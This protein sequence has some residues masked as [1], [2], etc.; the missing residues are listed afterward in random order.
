V[1]ELIIIAVYF[2]AM[3]AIGIWNRRKSREA[4]DFFVAGRK[5]STLFIT[6][7]LIATII[8]GSAIMVTGRLGFTRGISGIWWLL[9]GTAG[10]LILGIFLAGKV[11]KY[12]VYTL[13]EILDKQYGKSVSIV[14]S[15]IIVIAWTGVIGTQIMAAGSIMSTLGIGTPLLWMVVFSAVF[16]IYTLIGGQ[17]AIIKTDTI[18]SVI[19]FAGIFI[20]L[21]M[22]ISGLGG[23]GGLVE[24]LPAERFSFPFGTGFDGYD[25]VNL[26]LLVGLTYVVG[27]DIYSRLFCARDSRIAGKSAIGAALLIIPAALAITIIGMGASILY[28]DILPDSAF[29]AI[30]SGVLPP[31]LGGIVL[32]ALLCAFMSSADTTLMT[33]GTILSMDIIGRLNPSLEG[34]K[35]LA[36]SRFGIV[37]IGTASLLLSL[38]MGDLVNTILFA[39]TVYT[40]GLIIPILAGFYKD[41]LKVTPG[42]ALAAIIGG[43]GTALTARLFSISISI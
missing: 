30:I 17:H 2:L 42:G 39:Y 38:F 33:A 34:K 6:G 18:Q 27:P 23:I 37:I 31:F 12:G 26:L 7:S 20:A 36:V 41:R 19:I 24:K 43:G 5:G 40:G 4:D 35:L 8:G 13:T 21:A 10:L 3:V 1:T 28:P 22:V 9:S 25:L 32:A 11:R 29:P 16:I 15:L 14:G